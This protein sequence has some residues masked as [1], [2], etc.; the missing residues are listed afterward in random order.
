MEYRWVATSVR[1][2]VPQRAVS[3]LRYGYWWHVT[4]HIPAKRAPALVDA[5]RL[6]TE[7]SCVPFFGG[8]SHDSPAYRRV[9]RLLHAVGREAPDSRKRRPGRRSDLRNHDRRRNGFRAVPVRCRPG[10]R[11]AARQ[12]RNDRREPAAIASGSGSRPDPGQITPPGRFPAGG[13]RRREP[14]HLHE[15]LSG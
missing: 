7:K 4:G 12:R 2:F 8:R 1:G 5:K 3:Y 11:V 14:S 13:L 15:D 6:E 10:G 9:G